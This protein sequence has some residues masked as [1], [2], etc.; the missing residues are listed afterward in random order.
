MNTPLQALGDCAANQRIRETG[1][2]TP[3][4]GSMGKMGSIP[5]IPPNPAANLRH[6]DFSILQQCIHCGMCLPTCPT[7][8]STKLERNSPRGRIALMRNIAEG[9]L[10]VTKAFGD[11]L[12]FCL[13]CLAC[14]TACP[15]GVEYAPMFEAARADIETAGVLAAPQRNVVRE[16]M[17]CWLFTNPALLRAIGRILHWYQFW[18]AEVLVRRLGLLRLLP[19]QWRELEPLTPRVQPHFSDELIAPVES[20]A[21]RRYRVGMLTG[22]VQ[23][24]VYPHVNRD[25]VEVLVANGCEVFTPRAQHCCGS[26]HAHNG[27]LELAREMARRQIDGM[28]RT[29]GPLES[30]DAIISNAAGCGSHLKH[31]DHLLADDPEYAAKARAWSARLQD[32]HEWLAGHGLRPP[33]AAAEQTVTYHEACH[34]CHGQKISRQP[35]ELLRAIPGLKLVELP[36]ATWCCGSAGIYNITQPDMSR[37]LLDRKLANLRKTGVSVVAS[38]NT[39][40]CVQ[41]EAGLREAGMAV[42]VVHPVTL[43][44][45]AYRGEGRPDSSSSSSS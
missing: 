40:C 22:C 42:E 25:T 28:E 35:R 4:M 27:E 29:A 44:A 24:L 8:D 38:A 1:R 5:P 18:G 19:R 3:E 26:L 43:L 36:E 45:R 33:A 14:E 16:L 6:L 23:D 31:Y 41:L 15:A 37:K 12:Y 34:L 17:L 39:G 2:G 11:E 30:L 7:Y 32:V 13:G 20:P 21:E 10:E 9:K